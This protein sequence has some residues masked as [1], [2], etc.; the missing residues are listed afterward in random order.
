MS[1]YLDAPFV[2]G[3]AVYGERI[4]LKLQR[5]SEWSQKLFTVGLGPPDAAPRLIPAA[6]PWEPCMQIVLHGSSGE[7]GCT[8]HK[9][10][11]LG[12]GRCFRNDKAQARVADSAL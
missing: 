4:Y 1:R 7:D 12:V 9:K 10:G 6:E 8:G 2:V 3:E 5:S 11:T